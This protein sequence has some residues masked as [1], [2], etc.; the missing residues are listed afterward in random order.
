[1][2]ADFAW[3]TKKL[4]HTQIQHNLLILNGHYLKACWFFPSNTS[5]QIFIQSNRSQD[6]SYKKNFEKI[7]RARSYFVGL[8]CV[9]PK[10][11]ISYNISGETVW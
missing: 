11:C 8:V 3:K 1:M 10:N 6:L 9:L 4:K 2:V 5:E 7:Y